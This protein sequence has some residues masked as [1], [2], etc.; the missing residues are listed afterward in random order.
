MGCNE[1]TGS[2]EL[3]PQWEQTS[4]EIKVLQEQPAYASSGTPLRLTAGC[5]TN[6]SGLELLLGRLVKRT[7]GGDLRHVTSSSF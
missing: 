2:G 7:K 3:V 4:L 1:F 5:L 6:Q